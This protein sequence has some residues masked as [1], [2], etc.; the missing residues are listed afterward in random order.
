M[1]KLTSRQIILVVLMV[2][3]LILVLRQY[4]PAVELPTQGRLESKLK[5]LKS[6]QLDLQVARKNYQERLAQNQE[7]LKLAEPYWHHTSTARLDQ[8]VNSE[9]TRITR[10]AQLS[11]VAGSQKVDAGREK[12]GSNL[13]E[14]K[15]SVEFKGVSMKDLSLLFNQLENSRNGGKFRWEYCKISPSNPRTP[16]G[17]NVS[18]RFKVLALDSATIDFINMSESAAAAPAATTAKPR[19][20]K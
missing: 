11:G 17:V 19:K 18:A 2:V 9:F 20:L 1:K 8:E 14:V 10:L 6:R 3:M 16:Q 5:E 13:H 15:L 4:L 12:Q 7:L